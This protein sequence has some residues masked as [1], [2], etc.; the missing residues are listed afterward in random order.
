VQYPRGLLASRTG[1]CDDMSVLYC[2]L[3]ENVGI[4][5]A[6]LDGP[7]H[8]LMMF[9]AGIHPRNALAL[10]LADDMYVVRG[11]SVWIPVETTL[12][13]KSFV[14]AWAEGAS[15]YKRWSGQS[16]FHV[17]PVEDAW[18]EYVPSLP[19]TAPPS[20]VPPAA[21]AIDKRFAVDADTLKAWQKAYLQ[22]R[23]LAPLGGDKTG[24][25]AFGE[26]NRLALTHA[27]DGDLA[28]AR[29]TWDD[30]LASDPANATALNNRG[31]VALLGG[32]PDSALAFYARAVAADKDPGTI[33]NQ[34]LAE[35][36]KGDAKAAD[37][38]FE[39]ALALLPNPQAAERLLALPPAPGGVGSA[40]RLTTEEVRQRLRLAAGR[41]PR[42]GDA[43][44]AAV[45][46]GAGRGKAP[47]KV[48]SKVSGAR[49]SDV[50]S[51]ARV[52]YWK[53]EERGS[54]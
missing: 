40:R 18:T 28:S 35:F 4:P 48:L 21:D 23:F 30:A 1:D 19:A 51:N 47:A 54:K 49:A 43:P 11:E 44:A 17:T 52:V 32:Q 12:M 46:Q 45:G 25:R 41:V 31:N 10:S 36:A 37:A 16:D 6:F 5:T 50:G 39:Q 24:A 27:L 14:E 38:R 20:V 9:D 13:G 34:G 53:G 3:L 22:Q 2:T 8:I 33:L 42:P 29:G 15:I 26:S 7:G